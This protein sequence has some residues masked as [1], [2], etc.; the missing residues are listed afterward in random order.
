MTKEIYHAPEPA[1]NGKKILA[2]QMKTACLEVGSGGLVTYRSYY[3]S[4]FP[5]ALRIRSAGYLLGAWESERH[6]DGRRSQQ[7]CSVLF[8]QRHGM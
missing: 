3:N 7:L 4:S 1:L 5:N 6:E 8:G 2:N